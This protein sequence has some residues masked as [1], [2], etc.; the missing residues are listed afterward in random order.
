MGGRNSFP[1][2]FFLLFFF[3]LVVVLF[4]F[5]ACLIQEANS[6][7]VGDT[8]LGHVTVLHASN[9][10]LQ[11]E[12]R[13]RLEPQHHVGDAPPHAGHDRTDEVRELLNA[14]FR[15]LLIPKKRGR[16]TKQK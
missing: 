7:G 16:K 4:G 15:L 9:G 1:I 12:R 2:P 8:L 6:G 13:T 14:L 11:Y 5:C 3:L 10:Q